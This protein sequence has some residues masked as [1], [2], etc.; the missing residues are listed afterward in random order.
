MGNAAPEEKRSAFY[1]LN[2][3]WGRGKHDGDI[4]A[5][6]TANKLTFRSMLVRLSIASPTVFEQARKSPPKRAFCGAMV[7]DAISRRD[8]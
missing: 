7:T 8:P 5:D 4:I 6:E 2:R 1:G 3:H